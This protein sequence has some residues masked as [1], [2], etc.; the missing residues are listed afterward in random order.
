MS[1]DDILERCA[2]TCEGGSE[3]AQCGC[4]GPADC[5][6]RN[7]PSFG[8]ARWHAKERMNDALRR[9]LA[10]PVGKA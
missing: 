8:A 4:R 2:L 6:A 9:I 1:D 7:D 5:F 3:R 10:K